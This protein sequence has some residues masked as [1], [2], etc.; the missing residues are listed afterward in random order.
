MVHFI[1]ELVRHQFMNCQMY[2]FNNVCVG[3]ILWFRALRMKIGHNPTK[4]DNQLFRMHL[5]A[6]ARVTRTQA[7]R[8]FL[9]DLFVIKIVELACNLL[10]AIE[11]VRTSDHIIKFNLIWYSKSMIN[12]GAIMMN[13]QSQKGT[14][15]RHHRL[16]LYSNWGGGKHLS[17]Y[18]NF[19]T[20]GTQFSISITIAGWF[21]FSWIS[22]FIK[23]WST[24]N[25]TPCQYI[26]YFMYWASVR[27]SPIT[28]QE[29]IVRYGRNFQFDCSKPVKLSFDLSEFTDS[30]GTT[31]R[32]THAIKTCG[33][34]NSGEVLPGQ[35]I[36]GK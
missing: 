26:Q 2:T 19:A 28:S 34:E 24:W 13:A 21:V 9:S 12:D 33:L 18:R 1:C 6:R 27:W 5:S 10:V 4:F 32:L 30:V 16:G 17:T 7:S 29:Q 23:I 25:Y 3:I 8:P 15:H 14:A 20:K 31:L 35:Y 22:S 36:R 11:L